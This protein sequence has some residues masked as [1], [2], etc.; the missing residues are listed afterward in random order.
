MRL[1]GGAERGVPIGSPA[2]EQDKESRSL[3]APTVEKACEGL[4]ALRRSDRGF[5]ELGVWDEQGEHEQQ[6]P[7]PSAPVPLLPTEVPAEPAVPRRA[8][9]G[10]E[11]QEAAHPVGVCTAVLHVAPEPAT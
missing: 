4:A 3:K 1:E 2:F 11:V 8:L 6:E 5:D 10:G 9:F 7:V